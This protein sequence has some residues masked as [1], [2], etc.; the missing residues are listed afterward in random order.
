MYSSKIINNVSDS[1]ITIDSNGAIKSIN[2]AAADLLEAGENDIINKSILE[3][4]K[5]EKCKSV[6]A[7]IGTAAQL[8]C[9]LNNKRKHIIVSS[10]EF[11]DEANIKHIVLL[12]RDMTEFK[13]L[14]EHKSRNE[15]LTAMGQLASS[16][17]HEIRN[18]LNAIG[19]IVQQLR[20]DF[21]PIDNKSEYEELTELVYKE[22]KR[23]NEIIAAFLNFARPNPFK[24]EKFKLSELFSEIETQYSRLLENKGIRL[25]ISILDNHAVFW[26]K[27]QIKQAIINLIENAIS[28]IS[29]H[30]LITINAK[31]KESSLIQI[32]ITDNGIG[33]H[34]ESINKIF[35]LYYTTKSNGSGV[36]L[37]VVQKIISE[38]NGTIDVN[39]IINHG[40]TFIIKLPVKV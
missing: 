39:S 29:D 37:S 30:G 21:K 14:E 35:N 9:V 38:H 6:I 26:D 32:E 23:I 25:K 1:I 40:T 17:A 3:I 31:K 36:G 12:F 2:P 11:T 13:A 18:P 33:L 8:D 15:R 28:A 24:P 4:L 7:H 16:V 10:G 20:K 34:E 22:V 27:S 19:T 5:D